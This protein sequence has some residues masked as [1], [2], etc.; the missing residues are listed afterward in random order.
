MGPAEG[1][2]AGGAD[3][4]FALY[5]AAEDFIRKLISVST[6]CSIKIA[7]QK[8]LIKPFFNTFSS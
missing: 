5:L 6:E 3:G 2:T 8:Q 4:M 7:A 1:A